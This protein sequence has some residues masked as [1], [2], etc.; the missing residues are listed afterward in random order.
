M[1]EAFGL[2]DSDLK[3]LTVK[4]KNV[5]SL[6]YDL[7][8]QVSRCHC[9][10]NGHSA[11]LLFCELVEKRH[12]LGYFLVNTDL[13]NYQGN[14]EQYTTCGILETYKTTLLALIFKTQMHK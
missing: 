8:V 5:S 14:N 7:S 1:Q 12:S 6:N 2:G 4:N 3:L 10:Q 9:L 11:H 13:E